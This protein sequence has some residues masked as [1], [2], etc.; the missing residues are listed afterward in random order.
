MVALS[1]TEP[2]AHF[3]KR[4]PTLMKNLLYLLLQKLFP[5]FYQTLFSEMYVSE[6][7]V[8]SVEVDIT[9]A[10]INQTEWETKIEKAALSRFP[11]LRLFPLRYQIFNLNIDADSPQ[12]PLCVRDANA[13]VISR[14]ISKLSETQKAIADSRTYKEALLN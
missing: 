12:I 4:K 13:V 14:L 5:K 2:N 9:K 6:I 1:V 7:I 10:T 3:K 11:S 8:R